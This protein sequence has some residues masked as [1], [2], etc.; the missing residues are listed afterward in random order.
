M[1]LRRIV[2]ACLTGVLLSGC[3]AISD[4]MF[5]DRPESGTYSSQSGERFR[6]STDGATALSVTNDDTCLQFWRYKEPQIE[7]DIET[8]K[9]QSCGNDT[10]GDLDWTAVYS[11]KVPNEFILTGPNGEQ[12]EIAMVEKGLK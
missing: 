4:W 11:Y 8:L 5:G 7:A 12:L 6:V 3:N 1:P 2:I 9:G 10:F